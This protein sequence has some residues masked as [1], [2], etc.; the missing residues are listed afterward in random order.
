MVSSI[1]NKTV[2]QD[3]TNFQRKFHDYIIANTDLRSHLRFT[4]VFFR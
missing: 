4:S 1:L 2:Q 3:G